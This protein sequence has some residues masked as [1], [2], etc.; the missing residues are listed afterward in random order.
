[1]LCLSAIMGTSTQNLGFACRSP[2]T[3]LRLERVRL[4][5]IHLNSS[6]EGKGGEDGLGDVPAGS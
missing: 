5:D 1:M 6:K 2:M 4:T 3:R